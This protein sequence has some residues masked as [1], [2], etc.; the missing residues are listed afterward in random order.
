M[1]PRG[2]NS[3]QTIGSSELLNRDIY[4]FL[5]FLSGIWGMRVEIRFEIPSGID[6][7]KVVF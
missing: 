2:P 1:W 5:K 4:Q 3:Y 6:N 7:D